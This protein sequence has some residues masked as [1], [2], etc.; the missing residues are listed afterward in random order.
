MKLFV[1]IRRFFT[2]Y[3]GAALLIVSPVAVSAAPID[4]PY[5]TV[6]IADYVFGCMGSNGQTRQA[7]ANCSCSIDVVSSIISYSAY[8]RAETVLRL[9]QLTGEKAALFKTTARWKHA[10]DKLRRAQAEAEVRCF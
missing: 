1:S 6:A 2:L 3:I 7:L 4:N 8:E 10:V 5:P 9:R